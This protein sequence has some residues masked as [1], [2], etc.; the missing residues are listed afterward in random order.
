MGACV[1]IRRGWSFAAAALAVAVSA[2]PASAFYWY[3]PPPKTIVPPD[4]PGNPPT[5]QP[6]TDQ[7]PVD[8]P[9][10][11]PPGTAPEPATALAALAGLGAVAASRP[12]RKKK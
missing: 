11:T 8:V 1:L 10:G 7:P 5:D 9:P 4:V 3:G 6:P 2:G 12:W